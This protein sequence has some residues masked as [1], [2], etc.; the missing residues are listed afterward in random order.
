[1]KRFCLLCLTLIFPGLLSAQDAAGVKSA[2]EILASFEEAERTRGWP[3]KRTTTRSSTRGLPEDDRGI[4]YVRKDGAEDEDAGEDES[5]AAETWE[6]SVS[7]I[8]DSAQHF[9]NIL[10]G[11]GTTEFA[12]EASR[13]QVHE[14]A[15]AMKAKPALK[16][17]IEGHTCDIGKPRANKRLSERRADAVYA[18]LVQKGVPRR[19]LVTLGFGQSEPA[20]ENVDEPSRRKNRRV[21][22][23]VRR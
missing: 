7:V 14:I 11:F 10:F 16:F 15:A 19:Q 2:A 5:A 6:V 22:V 20:V 21:V 3:R 12:D 4:K 13:Q 1:M 17:L 8:P 18:A 9:E 23:Q